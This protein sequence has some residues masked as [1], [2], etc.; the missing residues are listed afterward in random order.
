MACRAGDRA[1][2]TDRAEPVE[3]RP[4]HGHLSGRPTKRPR[5]ALRRGQ[6][7]WRERAAIVLEYH[8]APDLAHDLLC[9][10]HWPDRNLPILYSG[11][12]SDERRSALRHLL[13]QSKP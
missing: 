10:D 1:A 6:D 13:L 4:N 9:D 8:A 3:H 11:V 12:Y 2:D 7:R 5:I